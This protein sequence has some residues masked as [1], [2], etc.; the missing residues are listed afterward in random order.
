MDGLE[1][2]RT[3][4]LRPI[5]ITSVVDCVGC[6]ATGTLRGN[7]YL[8]D[9]NRRQGS[10]GLGTEE[11]RTRVYEG[12]QLLWT[13][14]ALECEA[15]VT[16]EDI[17]IDK[18]VCTPQRHVYPDSDVTYWSATVKRD[19]IGVVP[20][21]MTFGVGSKATPMTAPLRPALVGR[22]TRHH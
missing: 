4:T 19:D 18:E 7:L 10:S 3:P 15:F 12:D 5:S 6:L 1:Q 20:Y 13:V 2:N 22:N 16:I 21:L 11:L 17:L 14:F 8:L 9:T